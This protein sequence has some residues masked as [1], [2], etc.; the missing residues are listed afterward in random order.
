MNDD[1]L[2]HRVQGEAERICASMLPAVVQDEMGEK[3]RVRIIREIMT[4]RSGTNVLI[5]AVLFDCRSRVVAIDERLAEA[6]CP[7]AVQNA[8]GK[9]MAVV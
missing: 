5:R 4:K 1:P 9:V 6:G 2:L 7:G 3:K 8:I